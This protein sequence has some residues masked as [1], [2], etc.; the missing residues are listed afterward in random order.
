MDWRVEYTGADLVLYD[1]GDLTIAL[2]DFHHSKALRGGGAA[3][4]R[5]RDRLAVLLVLFPGRADSAPVRAHDRQGSSHNARA[6]YAL[7]RHESQLD[8]ADSICRHPPGVV[9]WCPG[10]HSALREANGS[11]GNPL[12]H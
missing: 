9:C 12:A 6:L 8:R 10:E 5:G 7:C 1:P 3:D 2:Q 11:F 4:G